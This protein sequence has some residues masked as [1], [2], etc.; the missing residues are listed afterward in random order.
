MWS[1]VR[2]I[3]KIYLLTLLSVVALLIHASLS[4]RQQVQQMERGKVEALQRLVETATSIAA[5]YE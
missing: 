1:R 4:A 3:T 2:I 5:N